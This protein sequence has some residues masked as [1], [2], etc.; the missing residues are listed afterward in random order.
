MVCAPIATAA[1]TKAVAPPLP[2]AANNGIGGR[3]EPTKQQLCHCTDGRWWHSPAV[4][5]RGRRLR[6]RAALCEAVQAATVEGNALGVRPWPLTI[7]R[8]GGGRGDRDGKWG[9][10]WLGALDGW[11][12]PSHHVAWQCACSCLVATFVDDAH[13]HAGGRFIH[14]NNQP[15]TYRIHLCAA[16]CCSVRAGSVRACWPHM[17]ACPGGRGCI[18]LPSQLTGARTGKA[19]A[20]AR[21]RPGLGSR[22]R[23]SF[24]EALGAARAAK[25]EARRE[26]RDARLRAGAGAGK[27]LGARG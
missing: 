15:G 22:L 27:G 25:A 26:R 3:D 2:A 20:A 11:A 18:C 10:G 17:S 21:P 7:V 8:V 5:G 9:R 13:G 24:G 14:G 12:A 4:E 6:L 23:S 19:A 1:A 16:W